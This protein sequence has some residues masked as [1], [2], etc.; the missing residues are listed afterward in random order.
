MSIIFDVDGVLADFDLAFTSL[1]HTLFGTDTSNTHQQRDWNFRNVMTAQQ[2]VETWDVLMTTPNWWGS[3]NSLVVNSVFEQINEL[4][5]IHELY[6]VTHRMHYVTP[7]GEQTVI[8]LQDRGITNPRVIVSGKKGEVA[9][10]VGATHAIEDNWGNACAIHWIADNP[11]CK[12]FLLNRRYNEKARLI[13]PPN[14]MRINKIEEFIQAAASTPPVLK[15][16]ER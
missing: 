2:Q 10:A 6:F 7:A 14:I 13:I 11:Q 4:T 8:W 16:P 3:L 9:R 12:V 5:D 15:H 1:A